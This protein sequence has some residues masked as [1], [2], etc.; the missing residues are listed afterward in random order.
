MTDFESSNS[1]FPSTGPPST[2]QSLLSPGTAYYLRR[3]LR[4][5]LD[6]LITPDAVPIS[7]ALLN[8]LEA[9]VQTTSTSPETTLTELDH[10]AQRHQRLTNKGLK[11][12]QDL[13]ETEQRI[14][15]LLGL[16]L[17]E[18]HQEAT[19]LIVDDTPDNLR[20]LSTAL[21]DNGYAVRSAINGALALSTA[22]IIKPDLIL[23]DI[24]MPGLDGYEV[25]KRLKADPKTSDIPI[26]FISAIDQTVDKVKAFE[27]GGVD[28]ITKPVQIEEVLV[29]IQH[30]IKIWNLQKR[31]EDQSL[32]LQD[33]ISQRQQVDERSRQ[34]FEKAVSGIYRL[35]SDGHYLSVNQSMAQLYGYD[36][37][38]AMMVNAT[39]Q[40][41][42]ANPG[43]YSDF[44]VRIQVGDLLIGFESEIRRPDHTSIW[45]SETVRAVRDDLGNLLYYE[46]TVTDRSERKHAEDRERRSLRRIKKIL[47]ALFP[48]PIAERVSQKPDRLLVD[49]YDAATVLFAEIIGID[50]L[51]RNLVATDFLKKLN[52][53]FASFNRLAKQFHVEPVKT[54][55]NRYLAVGGI[56][57]SSPN[58]AIAMAEFALRIQNEMPKHQMG[59]SSPLN[60]RIGL[61]SGPVTAGIVGPTNLSYDLWGNT[62]SFAS[63][64]EQESV[65]NR[66]H[67]SAQTY[68]LIKSHYPCEVARQ[69]TSANIGRL[70]TYWLQNR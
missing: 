37:P 21:G 56:P 70:S 35:G 7:M 10:L 22:Q 50:M 38:E 28:Y 8:D 66:I 26:I 41:L 39:A 18:S 40:T 55:G 6:R 24:M 49:H 44:L 63:V 15:D 16:S 12:R 29:R 33:E 25:C 14:V 59:S 62:V 48:K 51:D 61:H 30:Q 36:S 64:L 2:L 32:R 68:E 65:P 17:K 67:L 3:L 9:L 5:N 52:Q 46:G 43:R 57:L 11:R 58:H 53:I 27:V 42:Y 34:L 45:V 4:Q 47:L 20:L 1:G 31:L 69:G 60:L 54:M 19:I 13:R 23:L